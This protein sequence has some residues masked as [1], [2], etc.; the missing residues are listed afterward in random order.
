MCFSAGKYFHALSLIAREAITYDIATKKE[1][2]SEILKTTAIIEYFLTCSQ[3]NIN[4]DSIIVEWFLV[5]ERFPSVTLGPVPRKT[6]K[7]KRGL[8]E[9][10]SKVFLA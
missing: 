8:N 9:I 2:Y 1:E 3:S 4:R 6:V 5:T 7:F 10:L